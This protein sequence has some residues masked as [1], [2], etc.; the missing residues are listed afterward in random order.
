MKY[1]LHP[2]RASARA[3]MHPEPLRGTEGER[4]QV[5]VIMAVFLTVIVGAAAM[6]T[7]VG[8]WYRAD[9]AAQATADAAALAGAQGLHLS[10]ADAAALA[11]QYATKNGGGEVEISFSTRVVPNDLITVTVSRPAPGTSARCSAIDEVEVTARATARAGIA[12]KARG[13]APIAVDEQ[14]PMLQCG[15]WGEPTQLRLRNLHDPGGSD[16]AGAFSLVNLDSL[17]NTGNVGAATLAD[18]ILDGYEDELPLGIYR[19]APSADF[20]SGHIRSAIN[21]RLGTEL[22]FPVYR[23]DHRRGLPGGVRRGRL[24]GVRPHL[25]HRRRK[26]RDDSRVLHAGHLAGA[27]GA[28]PGPCPI[29]GSGQ[30]PSSND[31]L[32]TRLAGGLRPP[33]HSAQPGSTRV[34]AQNVFAADFHSW[35]RCAMS[36]ARSSSL[37]LSS[38]WR[39]EGS[40]RR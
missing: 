26:S 38:T 9:R 12:S 6:A 40:A 31:G 27:R 3:A 5:A 25:V 36:W 13:V 7:D 10:T 28:R 11:D 16:A 29:S 15:C 14:H 33:R 8:S 1:P 35:R 4:G 19:S 18:W 37:P 2:V 24:G 32:R 22:L 30:S 23:V 34:V 17:Y 21:T 39:S 20:N